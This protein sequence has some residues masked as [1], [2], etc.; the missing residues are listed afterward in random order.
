MTQETNPSRKPRLDEPLAVQRPT[1]AATLDWL[2]REIWLKGS[3][4]PISDDDI[5]GYDEDGLPR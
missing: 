1:S 4:A 2:K 3:T 5:L